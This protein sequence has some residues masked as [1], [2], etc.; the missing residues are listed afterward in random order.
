MENKLYNLN[1]LEKSLHYCN[2]NYLKRKIN[3]RIE[4]IKKVTN[5]K[6]FL[7]KIESKI[8]PININDL[9]NN[10]SISC[11]ILTYNEERCIERCINS[12]INCFDEIIVIDTGST[13]KTIELLK[14]FGEKITLYKTKWNNNFSEVRNFAIKKAQSDWIF[15][16]DADEYLIDMTYDKLHKLICGFKQF[17]N[18]NQLVL[19]PTIIDE[20]IEY[21]HRDV[22]RIFYNSNNISYYGAIHEEVRLKYGKEVFLN[23][24]I[25]M[26]HDGYKT[27]VLDA[28]NKKERNL[29]ILNNMLK[30]EPDNVRWKYFYIKDGF[31]VLKISEI[32]EMA[33]KCLLINKEKELVYDNI[34]KNK[35][36]VLILQLLCRA[37]IEEKKYKKAKQCCYIME[38]IIPENSDSMYFIVLC[39]YLETKSHENELLYKVLNYR[40]N[41]F[42]SQNNMFSTEGFHIDLLIGILLFDNYVFKKSF[43]Y[44]EFLKDKFNNEQTIKLINKFLEIKENKKCV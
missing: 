4:C 29:I 33:K 37:Y 14:E 13:D 18:K 15:F 28:K 16:I 10:G 36:T 26:Y 22:P 8:E 32:K 25:I 44:F 24:E 39:D 20:G 9:D 43:Q 17:S 23:I 19:S 5:N 12:I 34:N 6:L 2:D 27:T 42:S 21:Y 41:H 7:N 40:K 38:K 30:E 3:E 35:Y 31:D 11:I 1:Y